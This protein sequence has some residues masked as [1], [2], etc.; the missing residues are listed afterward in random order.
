MT[1][2]IFVC[3]IALVSSGLLGDFVLQILTVVPLFQLVS[4]ED[5]SS[6]EYG[7]AWVCK[8]EGTS[9]ASRCLSVLL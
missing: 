7:C 8:A 2:Y 3:C 6:W 4:T 1:G 9:H 5:E